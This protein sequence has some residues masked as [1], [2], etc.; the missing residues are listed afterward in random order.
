MGKISFK[1]HQLNSNNKMFKKTFL[2]DNSHVVFMPGCSLSGYRQD[3]IIKIYEYLKN[4][5]DELGISLSCCY[6]PSIM[7]KDYDSFNKYYKTLDNMLN[8][9]NIK[10]VITACPNCYKTIKENS[11]NIKVT[12]LLEVIKEK[13]IDK[14]LLNN[15]IDIEQIFTIQDSCAIRGNESIYESCRFILDQLGIKYIEFEKNKTKSNCC[16]SIFVDDKK[17]LEQIKRRCEQ[18]DCDNIISYCETCAKSMLEGGKDSIHILDLLFNEDVINKKMFTQKKISSFKTWE[19][20]YKINNR[21]NY[22]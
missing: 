19:N 8:D 20:R 4:H 2:T 11:K 12:F 3:I 13:G 18:T 14:E 6:K 21:R 22:E 5:I 16:G 10:E 17:R 7:I 15:Y 9:N 1:F